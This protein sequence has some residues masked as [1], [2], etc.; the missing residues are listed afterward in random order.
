MKRRQ[1]YHDVVAE[2][3]RRFLQHMLDAHAGNRTYTART[4][5]L[6]RSYFIRLLRQYGLGRS[7]RPIPAKS[8]QT[9]NASHV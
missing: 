4:L 9:E 3:R 2:F 6:Q 8:T 5:G 7:N 1:G